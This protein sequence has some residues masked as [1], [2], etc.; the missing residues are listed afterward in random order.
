MDIRV[1]GIQSTTDILECMSIS[2]IQHT[3]VQDKHL[4]HLKNIIITGWPSTKDELNIDI[5]PYWSY[6]DDL[7]AIDGVAMKGRC[8][9]IPAELKQQ[10]LDQLH[11]NH[12]GIEK[13]KLITHES[14]YWVNINTDI[15][16]HIKGC[17]TCLEFQQTQ[18]KEKIIH[19]DISLRPWEV[20]GADIFHLNNKHYLCII[21]YPS[22]FQ[23]IKRME[24]LSTESL[25]ATIKVIFAEYGIAYRLMLDAGTNLFQR[26]SEV[27]AAGSTSC[28]QCH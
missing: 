21:D 5:R 1:D 19:H 20:L 22:K 2:Q 13:T 3:M 24:G 25:I 28:K 6:R 11:P 14:V 9:I 26:N 12:M 7:S 18:P 16:K 23:V 17:N 27:S 8:I 10:V 4:Q 15:E